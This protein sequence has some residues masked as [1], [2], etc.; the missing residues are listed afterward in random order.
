MSEQAG[1]RRG[2]GTRDVNHDLLRR[3]HPDANARRLAWV[4]VCSSI[5]MRS[6]SGFVFQ[7]IQRFQMVSSPSSCHPPRHFQ[8]AELTPTPALLLLPLQEN[9]YERDNACFFSLTPAT[10]LS[11][12]PEDHRE[13]GSNNHTLTAYATTAFT[14]TSDDSMRSLIAFIRWVCL[15]LAFG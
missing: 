9:N 7:L 11:L 10:R 8:L 1:S 15:S 6:R 5:G 4:D 12:S 3:D 13:E 2:E 14:P